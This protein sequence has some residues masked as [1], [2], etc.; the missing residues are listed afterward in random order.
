[1]E[2]ETFWTLVKDVSH[3]EFELFLMFIFDGVIG[4]ILFP[5]F[6]KWIR[7]HKKDDKNT[8]DL[9]AEVNLLKEQVKLLLDK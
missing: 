3:W 9:Q 6:K 4:L 7:H 5:C 8:A 2:H 1:M